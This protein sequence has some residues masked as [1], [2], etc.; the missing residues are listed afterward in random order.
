MNYKI[1]W[2]SKYRPDILLMGDEHLDLGEE[3]WGNLMLSVKASLDQAQ[4]PAVVVACLLNLDFE[5]E[6][7]AL[8]RKIHYIKEVD[9]S[10]ISLT[11]T[12]EPTDIE[13]VQAQRVEE[14]Q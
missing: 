6:D 13:D 2:A 11:A 7:P 9:R 5:S 10:V 1:F 12:D 8:Q 14:L 3:E 4:A